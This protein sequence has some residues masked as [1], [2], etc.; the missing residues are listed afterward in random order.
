MALRGNCRKRSWGVS[1]VERQ[2]RDRTA[3]RVYGRNVSQRSSERRS[4]CSNSFIVRQIVWLERSHW[5]F[6]C[7]SYGVEVLKEMPRVAR[8]DLVSQDTKGA[9]LSLCTQP[10]KPNKQNSDNEHSVTVDDFIFLHEKTNGKRECSSTTI[11][12][13]G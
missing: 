2:T 10:G 1:L 4:L 7:G 13:Y 6:P 8:K 12:R 3:W 11:S 9:P 5:L